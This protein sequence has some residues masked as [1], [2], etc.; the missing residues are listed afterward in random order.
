MNKDSSNNVIIEAPAEPDLAPHQ[1]KY[2]KYKYSNRLHYWRQKQELLHNH[3]ARLKKAMEKM[4]TKYENYRLRLWEYE[5][6]VIN[7]IVEAPPTLL[8]ATATRLGQRLEA[9]QE[10][11][12]DGDDSLDDMSD[13][14][15]VST[16]DTEL[17]DMREALRRRR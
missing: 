6:Y 7:H 10:D 13:M 3:I 17:A 9:L 16:C 4:K 15:S 11:E 5:G 8:E 14:Q 12:S 2:M 1:T